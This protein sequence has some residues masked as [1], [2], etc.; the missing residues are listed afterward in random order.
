MGSSKLPFL[1]HHLR[2]VTA[3]M[4]LSLQVF[5]PVTGWWKTESLSKEKSKGHPSLAAGAFNLFLS[6]E[7]TRL[8]LHNPRPQH[9]F[10][11]LLEHL[12]PV[13]RQTFIHLADWN[14]PFTEHHINLVEQHHYHPQCHCQRVHDWTKRKKK[15]WNFPSRNKPVFQSLNRMMFGFFCSI[16]WKFVMQFYSCHYVPHL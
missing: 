6:S 10:C 5:I 14:I 15:N 4:I 13:K 3:P 9:W 1:S 12:F 8:L 11:V 16:F 2:C 7:I